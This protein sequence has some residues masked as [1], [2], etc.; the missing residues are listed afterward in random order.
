MKFRSLTRREMLLL[1][2]TS[3]AGLLAG[4]KLL[5]GEETAQQAIETVDM[6]RMAPDAKGGAELV[7]WWG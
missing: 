3:A 7:N 6:A 4:R 1:S 5:A 2:A